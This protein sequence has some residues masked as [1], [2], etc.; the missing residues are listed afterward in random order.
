MP[1]LKSRTA[2]LACATAI[3]GLAIVIVLSLPRTILQAQ[4]P[5]ERI[6][7][8]SAQV[9]EWQKAAGGKMSFEVASVKPANAGTFTPPNFALDFLD[10]FSGANPHGRFVA[11]FP[12]TTY[13]RFAYK[14]FPYS[15][16]QTDAM[17]AHAPKWVA[18][19]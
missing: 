1:L 18:M 6:S 15:E 14:L 16:E 17:L 11:Q 12:L 5:G 9:P 13:V 10:S 2:S 8:E 3:A 4:T 19:D 7:T